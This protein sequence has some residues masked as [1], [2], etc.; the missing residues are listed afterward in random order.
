MTKINKLYEVD[1][2]NDGQ[3]LSFIDNFEGYDMKNGKVFYH[4]K[5]EHGEG[6]PDTTKPSNPITLSMKEVGG[7]YEVEAKSK[8]PTNQ[9][10]SINITIGGEDKTITILAGNTTGITNDVQ[11]D[12]EY[13]TVVIKNYE[14][15]DVD[16][17]YMV[18]ST[19]K[20]GYFTITYKLDGVIFSS[21]TD[22]VGTAVVAPTIP[23]KDGFTIQGWDPNITSI[24]DYDV[25]VNASYVSTS[26][27]VVYY[28]VMIM[29]EDEALRNKDNVKDYA[30][31]TQTWDSIDIADENPT[32]IVLRRKAYPN[33]DPDADD[34]YSYRFFLVPSGLTPY[35]INAANLRINAAPSNV[36]H[37]FDMAE[38]D[39]IIWDTFELD[40]N[41]YNVWINQHDTMDDTI[42]EYDYT[43][44]VIE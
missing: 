32:P 31:L 21:I 3:W 4:C 5:C 41:T 16:Y 12:Y 15:T 39:L 24:P 6:T 13:N 44:G 11:S 26:P 17:V 34:I 2:P 19:I 29:E 14:T 25:E 23:P 28:G 33:Y 18:N 38:Y 10:V 36:T 40:G 1:L 22:F 20:N 8:Y 42:T 30:S 7:K 9:D 27:T 37:T 43:F 35:I